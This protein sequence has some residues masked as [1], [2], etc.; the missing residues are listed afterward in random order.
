MVVWKGAVCF[1]GIS[2]PLIC[3]MLLRRKPAE[4]VIWKPFGELSQEYIRTCCIA[5]W[6]DQKETL[7]IQRVYC[8]QCISVFPYMMTWHGRPLP[9]ATPATLG[10]VDPAESGLIFKHQ[11]NGLISAFGSC[12]QYTGLI[13][14]RPRRPPDPQPS[15]VLTGA[16]SCAIRGASTHCTH[17][18]ARY[19]CRTLCP[20]LL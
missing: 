16:F 1:P 10:F 15:D 8:A 9:W 7:S 5:I 2:M 4:D 13:F 14:L 6:H 20:M 18:P 12:I 3:A 11:S 19:P 17:R